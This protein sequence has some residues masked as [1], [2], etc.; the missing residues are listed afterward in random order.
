MQLLGGKH[1]TSI[2]FGM[3]AGDWLISR[4]N[5]VNQNVDL[6]YQDIYIYTIYLYMQKEARYDSGHVTRLEVVSALQ[7]GK[8]ETTKSKCKVSR[9]NE[10]IWLGQ[11]CFLGEV[12]HHFCLFHGNSNPGKYVHRADE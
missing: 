10:T 4:A 7:L 1:R 3:L 6:G 5:P 9:R 12:Y 2:C 8:K 11:I